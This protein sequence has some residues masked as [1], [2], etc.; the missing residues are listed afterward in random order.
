MIFLFNATGCLRKSC[1]EKVRHIGALEPSRRSGDNNILQVKAEHVKA[2][3]Q[4]IIQNVIITTTKKPVVGA[5][6]AATPA[7][8]TNKCTAAGDAGEMMD[9]AATLRCSLVAPDLY[10]V[11]LSQPTG[12]RLE[13]RRNS[14][15]T[16]TT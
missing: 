3:N 10:I 7:V 9:H 15:V 6:A 8:E 5:A 12:L 11:E 1:P 13:N 14:G 16:M 4:E 2:H